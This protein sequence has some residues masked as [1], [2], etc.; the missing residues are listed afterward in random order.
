[1][2]TRNLNF[3]EKIAKTI[4]PIYRYQKLQFPRRF[5][6]FKKVV[7]RELAPPSAKD[8]PIIKKEFGL[9]VKAIE[10]K[11]YRNYTLGVFIIFFFYYFK[12]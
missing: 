1:M 10:T 12:I 6:I 2:T 7:I 3:A 8:W 4:G 5:E 9:I 11:A